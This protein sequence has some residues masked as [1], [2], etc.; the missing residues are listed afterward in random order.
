MGRPQGKLPVMPVV[1]ADK[2]RSVLAVTAGLLPQLGRL[3]GRQQQLL[4]PCLI[5]LLPD[6]PRNAV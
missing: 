3:H 5:H 1:Q 4:G 2:L 6:Y